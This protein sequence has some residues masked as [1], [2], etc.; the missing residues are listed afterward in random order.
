MRKFV[1]EGH[2]VEH[3]CVDFGPS[4]HKF[5]EDDSEICVTDLT[6]GSVQIYTYRGW[7][8]DVIPISGGVS[9]CI[10]THDH[11]ATYDQHSSTI[12]IPFSTYPVD[13]AL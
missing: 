8:H 11:A 12:Q 3:T 5:D 1:V 9:V 7:V 6:T 10:C 13:T 4:G 2:L